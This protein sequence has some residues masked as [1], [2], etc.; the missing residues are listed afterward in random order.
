MR[1][2]INL[3]NFRP[4]RIGGTETYLREFVAHLP[5]VIRD[6]RVV[7][8]TSR[9]VAAEFADSPLPVASVPWTTTQLCGW[10]LLEA[11]S[12]RCRALPIAAAI[13]RLEP[14]VVLFPQQSI[15]PKRPPA[16]A[17][18]VVHDLYHLTCPQHLS[19]LQRWFRG[20]SYPAALASADHIIAV[21]EF[22]KRDVLARHPGLSKRISAIPHGVRQFAP[23]SVAPYSN[24]AGPYVY[25]PA[26][27][28]P[29]KNHALLLH[30]VAA[31]RARG[32][33]PYRLLLSGAR[34]RHWRGLQRRIAQL[35]LEGTVSHLGQVPYDTVLRLIRG[36]AC[37]VFPSRFEGFGIPVVEATALERKVITSQLAVFEEIGV[38]PDCRIDFADLD[39]FAQ[40]LAN[41]APVP[42]LRQ[43]WTWSACARTTL[44]VLCRTA[45]SPHMLP[46]ERPKSI[47]PAAEAGSPRRAA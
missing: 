37:V 19:A 25:Y 18:L 36:A 7:L 22:T 1:I 27:T 23:G 35:R 3:L 47:A 32:R 9:D 11:A 40:A 29:H 12:E 30:S 21:S 24:A 44:D 38:P 26:A 14:D 16:P 39:A 33:F 46:L 5:D 13:A 43:P 2:L 4:G 41:T 15:F 34:S 42:F 20:R 10:R 28:L 6:E 8:L 45:Q 17:V 31:L